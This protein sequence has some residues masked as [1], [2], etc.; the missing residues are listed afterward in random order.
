MMSS[1]FLFSLATH[2]ISLLCLALTLLQLAMMN[3]VVMYI[4]AGIIKWARVLRSCLFFAWSRQDNVSRKRMD[5]VA[6]HIDYI[7][8]SLPGQTVCKCYTLMCDLR[9]LT[10]QT[11][12][13]KTT[14]SNWLSASVVNSQNLAWPL[15]DSH[16]NALTHPWIQNQKSLSRPHDQRRPEM[17]STR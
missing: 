15:W 13:A 3:A 17:V 7:I 14:T 8:W 10:C 1:L 2:F 4:V 9:S 12:A 11:L 6:L 5:W 16:L